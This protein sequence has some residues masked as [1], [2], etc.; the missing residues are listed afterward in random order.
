MTLYLRIICQQHEALWEQLSRQGNAGRH[1]T[2]PSNEE[3]IAPRDNKHLRLEL[4]TPFTVPEGQTKSV[5]VSCKSVVVFVSFWWPTFEMIQSWHLLK[6]NMCASLCWRIFIN[7]TPERSTYEHC[8]HQCLHLRLYSMCVSIVKN[9]FLCPTSLPY[10][11]AVFLSLP[12]RIDARW[13]PKV[14][15]NI[16]LIKTF[17]LFAHF[18]F[19][20]L[21]KINNFYLYFWKNFYFTAFFHT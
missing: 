10:N 12:R 5:R 13:R 9:I 20:K 18:E 14:T 15:P 11:P 4:V 6:Y 17:L 19:C 16:D 3:T 1:R 21:I 2:S 7:T 8:H